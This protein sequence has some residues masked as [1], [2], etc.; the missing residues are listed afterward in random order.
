MPREIPKLPQ[1]RLYL[2]AAI[3]GIDAMVN[4]KLMGT[5][6]RFHIIGVLS[7][8]RAVQ[9]SLLNHD[10]TISDAHRDAIDA[11]RKATPLDTPEL[12]FI[13]SARNQILKGGAFNS[14]AISS[15]SSTGSG[16]NYTITDEQYELVYY[17]GEERRDLLAELRNA[18]AWCERLLESIE[19]KLPRLYAPD[20]DDEPLIQTPS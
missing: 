1:A 13:M 18:V 2:K 12:A 6:Y 14:Y 9:H 5:P 20:E 8:L 17:V 15:E 19:K 10:R 16:A 3:Y 4:G 7:S 11:W